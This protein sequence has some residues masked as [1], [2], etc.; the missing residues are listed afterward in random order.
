MSRRGVVSAGTWC[1]DLNK[2]IAAWPQEDT[3][4]EVIAWEREGGGSG[5]NM[6]T[7]LKRLDPD[8]PIEAMGLIGDDEDGRF[9]QRHCDEFGIL[10][11]GLRVTDKDV[12]H[13]TDC[14]N[15]LA[16]GRRTHIYICGASDHL[17]PDHF[18][19]RASNAKF[20]HLGLPTTHK[21]MDAPWR[22]F[23]SGWAATL[24]AARDCGLKTNM[25]LVT[26]KRA[27]VGALG[28]TCAPH[29]NFLIVNDFEI[30]AVA[31][32]ETRV[33]GA[34]NPKLIVEA[35]RATLALGSLEVVVSHFP[36]GAIAAMRGGRV[37]ALGSV[38]MPQPEIAGVNGAGDAFAAGMLYGLHEGWEVEACMRL[39]H[40]CA[41][42]SM[43]EVATTTGVAR[44]AE[45]LALAKRW[46]FRPAPL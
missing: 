29:L 19:F 34:A 13:V 28:R 31:D 44:A 8:L 26:T 39:A 41:A 23:P 18:D 24:K 32:V 20:L 42:A 9:L 46:G 36:E 25:E 22:G 6:A 16:S 38:A 21:I 1:V 43:R 40:A 5:Y 11:E 4:N 27:A 12:T 10:R 15:S 14:F 37:F 3:A 35:L 45:C 2:T 17:T 7:D 33:N 30:G